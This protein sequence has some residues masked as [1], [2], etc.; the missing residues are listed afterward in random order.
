MYNGKQIKKRLIAFFKKGDE[1]M[2]LSNIHAA[3]EKIMAS[4]QTDSEKDKQ[5]SSL[6]SDMEK[7]FSIP[8][9]RSP[10]W[11]SKNR[12]VISMYRKIAKSRSI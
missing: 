6:M 8:S 7:A 11:E 5:L 10:E 4:N 9:L 2:K 3:Y 1:I 12:A